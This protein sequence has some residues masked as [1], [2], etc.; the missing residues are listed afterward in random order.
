MKNRE[1]YFEDVKVEKGEKDDYCMFCGSKAD[2]AIL[3][4]IGW[5]FG[6]GMCNK[7]AEFFKKKIDTGMNLSE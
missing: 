5:K 3:K 2:F 6:F 4:T 1:L 7:C